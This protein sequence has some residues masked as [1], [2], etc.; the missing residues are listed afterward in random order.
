MGRVRVRDFLAGRGADRAPFVPFATD[1][2]VRLEQVTREELLADPQTLTRTLL[3]F[4]ALFGLEAVVVPVEREAVAVAAEAIARL[5]T[6]LGD[7]AAIVALLPGPELGSA[8]ALGLQHVDIVAVRADEPEPEDLA[9]LWNVARYYAAPTLLVTQG[10]DA[11]GADAV[12]SLSGAVASGSARMGVLVEPGG[13]LPPLPDGGFYTTWELPADT[14][15][16]A[17]RELVI[18][19]SW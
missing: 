18:E 16:D 4:Q 3:G 10:A 17:F 7:R 19:A 14:D 6:L 8:N 9:P 15:V 2:A 5:R 13:P 12:V 11:A 1:F